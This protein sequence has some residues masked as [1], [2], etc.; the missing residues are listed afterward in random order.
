MDRFFECPHTIGV[1]PPLRPT[2]APVIL[3]LKIISQHIL[4]SVLDV[5][6]PYGKSSVQQ[7]SIIQND[8]CHVLI[9]VKSKPSK[10]YFSSHN[11]LG[12]YYKPEE[13]KKPYISCPQYNS[14]IYSI[15]NHFTSGV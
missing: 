4:T 8:G 10:I 11:M 13:L 1:N 6:L 14:F 12:M 15:L 2:S 7:K 5:F 9:Y 3:G